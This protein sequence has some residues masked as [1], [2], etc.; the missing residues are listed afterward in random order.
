MEKTSKRISF[1]RTYQTRLPQEGSLIKLKNLGKGTILTEQEQA[2]LRESLIGDLGEQ[3]GL[4]LVQGNEQEITYPEM[5][6]SNEGTLS[7]VGLNEKTSHNTQPQSRMTLQ[8]EI[9]KNVLMGIPKF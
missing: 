7:K 3:S 6:D 4:I 1:S 2:L 5:G 9:S 8:K